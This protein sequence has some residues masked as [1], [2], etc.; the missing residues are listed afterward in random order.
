MHRCSFGHW[1][2]SRLVHAG[3]HRGTGQKACV[4]FIPSAAS[5]SSFGVSTC[6]APLTARQS[7]RC[8][9]DWISSTFGRSSVISFCG[10]RFGP[11]AGGG[12]PLTTLEVIRAMS[13]AV[14]LRACYEL[15]VG[16]SMP[17]AGP[18]LSVP[19]ARFA[20]TAPSAATSRHEPGKRL[21]TCPCADPLSTRE[22][23]RRFPA[24]TVS[25]PS[26]R[27][28]RRLTHLDPVW[29]GR[30]TPRRRSGR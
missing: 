27:R 8:L 15:R 28:I 7:Q 3:V 23:M 24:R 19:V 26:A 9:S 5:R 6:R 2:V 13:G 18:A 10:L 20:A 11:P 21:R 1:P 16:S 4:K 12:G 14:K 29:A 22:M 25:E 17:R 30:Y